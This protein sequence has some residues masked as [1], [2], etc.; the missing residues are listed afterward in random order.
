MIILGIETTAHTFGVGIFSSLKGILANVN[1]AYVPLEGGI[2]PREAAEHHASVAHKVLSKALSIAN[3]K[4]EDITAVAA[5]FGPGLGPCLRVGCS[6]ARALAA[7]YSKPL[8][9][10]NHCVAHIEIAR[11]LLKVSDPLVV[12]VSGGNTIIAAYSDGRYRVFGETLDIALGN[13]LDVFARE[14]GLGLPGPPHLEEK[15]KKAK[16]FIELPYI[17]KGQDLSLSGLLTKALEIASSD[18]NYSLEDLCY[19]FIET[20]YGMLIEVTERALAH[21]RKNS[22]VLTG[23]VARSKVLQKKLEIMCK[24]HSV[25]FMTVPA[26]YAGDNGG[27]IAYTGYLCYSHGITIPVEKSYIRPRWRLDEVDI[28]WFKQD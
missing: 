12:Y 4:M 24:L 9:P 7:H 20:A 5:S 16:K 14:I 28:P 27:M 6:V 11:Y 21:T 23:G 8:V 26:E 19:S 13:C 25:N 1:D 10:V 22:V 18:T 17:V 2:H 15:A 3:V